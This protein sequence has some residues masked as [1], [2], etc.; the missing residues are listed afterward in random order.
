MGGAILQ[1][2]LMSKF[3][4]RLSVPGDAHIIGSNLRQADIE[5]VK[6][7]SGLEPLASLLYSYKV[8][9]LAYTIVSSDGLPIGMFGVAPFTTKSGSL[10]SAWLLGSD[11]LL[12][13]KR[14]FLAETKQYVDELHT[15]FPYLTAWVDNR[16]TASLKWLLWCGF[17]P[18][19]SDSNYNQSGYAFTNMTRKTNV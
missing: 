3:T 4:V 18:T 5:E 8:S 10:G 17:S 12:K 7:S 19:R 11:D 14:Q 15:H 1:E 2:E 9:I 6:A 13:Y 16:N